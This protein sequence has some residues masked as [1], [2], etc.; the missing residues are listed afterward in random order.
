MYLM[1]KQRYWQ[2]TLGQIIFLLFPT[3]ILHNIF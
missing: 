2:H 3:N 1:L